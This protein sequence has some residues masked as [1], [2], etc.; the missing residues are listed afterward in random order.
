[1]DEG[2]DL[3]ALLEVRVFGRC[4]GDGSGKITSQKRSF[5]AKFASVIFTAVD[6]GTHDNQ[7]LC[8]QSVGFYASAHVRGASRVSNPSR[9]R[10][11]A[12]K[13]GKMKEIGAR[14]GL[15]P[16]ESVKR[17]KT[18]GTS[19]VDLDEDLSLSW[20]GYGYLFNFGIGLWSQRSKM[21]SRRGYENVQDRYRRLLS[22]SLERT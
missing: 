19:I 16:H 20:G 15:L 5:W 12:S 17:A 3:C 11:G 18:Y 4:L 10:G 21:Y 7:A 2:Y 8:F 1:V 6:R 13:D 22:L 14:M 9:W